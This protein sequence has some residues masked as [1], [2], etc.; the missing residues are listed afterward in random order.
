M[1]C[2]LQITSQK[3]CTT[4]Q[5]WKK[6]KYL[7]KT[8]ILKPLYRFFQVSINI[9]E[10]LQFQIHTCTLHIP[11][12]IGA[13]FHCNAKI[14]SAKNGA[15]KL[16]RLPKTAKWEKCIWKFKICVLIN[17]SEIFQFQI[18][19]SILHT[20]MIIGTKFRYD[21]NTLSAKKE[22][23]KLWRLP[24]IAKRKHIWKFKRCIPVKEQQ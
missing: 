13:K 14:L 2:R 5:S 21:V 9:T 24:E 10:I 8:S 16:W 19:T 23:H 15:H 17:I 7:G 1:K 4:F 6:K 18:H 3:L 22:A 12:I 20:V 11:K